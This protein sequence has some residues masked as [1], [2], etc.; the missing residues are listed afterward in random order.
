MRDL[1]IKKSRQIVFDNSNLF[2]HVVIQCSRNV[3]FELSGRPE[4]SHEIESTFQAIRAGHTPRSM[5]A[6]ARRSSKTFPLAT[7]DIR[8]SQSFEG[9]ILLR[10]QSQSI[11]RGISFAH[12]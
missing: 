3:K 12:P 5:R 10:P 8:E 1:L 2:T 6:K 4:N 7:N 9:T 11:V